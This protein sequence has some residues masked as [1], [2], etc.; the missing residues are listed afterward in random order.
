MSV[1]K[2]VSQLQ[3][4]YYN[5]RVLGY[6]T[7]RDGGTLVL[8]A[9]I[10]TLETEVFLDRRCSS[11]TKGLWFDRYP[12]H[13]GATELPAD[14]VEKVEIAAKEWGTVYTMALP[15]LFS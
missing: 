2:G 3:P 15:H 14:L 4:P 7:Y 6:D 12:G 1:F 10:N 13:E 11:P 9:R 5:V 8:R